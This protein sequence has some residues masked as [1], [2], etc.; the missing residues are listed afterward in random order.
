[1]SDNVTNKGHALVLRKLHAMQERQGAIQRELEEV[2][3]TGNPA[4]IVELSRENGRLEKS[5]ALYREYRKLEQEA[6]EARMIAQD[7][8]EDVEFRNLAESQW[9]ELNGRMEQLL[10]Q[11]LEDFLAGQ[12]GTSDSMMLEIRAGTGGDEAALFARDLAEMYRRFSEKNNWRFDVLDFSPTEQGGFREIIVNVRGAGAVE[13]LAMESGGHRVQRVPQTETQGRIHTSAATVAVLPEPDQ[14]AIEINPADVREDVSRAGGPGGQN[15]NKVE[16]AVQLTHLPTGLV[17]RMREERSQHK[18]RDKAWRILRARVF[19]FYDQQRRAARS[20][21][22]REMIGSGDRNERIRT[23][24]FP[25]N[26]LTDHR[27]NRNFPLEKIIAGDM[28]ELLRALRD[29]SREELLES[30]LDA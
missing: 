16:S 29:R 21:A 24:N 30:M 11:M 2:G 12:R 13:M 3:A 5:L 28:F 22:R 18:N 15:V 9:I 23:Y 26:R 1:M 7:T 19:E 27:L 10:E 14:S 17:V 25:Q 8:S 20:D 6:T 4:R